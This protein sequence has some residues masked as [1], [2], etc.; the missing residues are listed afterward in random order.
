M[1]GWNR[2]SCVAVTYGMSMICLALALL[3]GC[4]LKLVP[5]PSAEI[6]DGLNTGNRQVAFLFTIAVPEGQDASKEE[7][8]EAKKAYDDLLTTLSAV[9][10]SLQARP[11]PE[12]PPL[13]DA[14]K[15]D[16]LLEVP[17]IGS[18]N[19]IIKQVNKMREVHQK[20]GL[21]AGEVKVFHGFIRDFLIDALTYENALKR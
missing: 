1:A 5:P 11:T 4:T 10:V 6:L 21:T 17:T 3:V 15:I 14:K 8:P 16:K 12:A 18:V 20:Q 13:I 9:Q 2:R 19:N 7:F